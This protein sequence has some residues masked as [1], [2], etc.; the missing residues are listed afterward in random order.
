L[1]SKPKLALYAFVLDFYGREAEIRIKIIRGILTLREWV[2]IEWYL[3]NAA[4]LEKRNIELLSKHDIILAPL[5]AQ[6]I[7]KEETLGFVRH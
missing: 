3:S 4:C 6:I 2:K 1:P 5:H 7:N